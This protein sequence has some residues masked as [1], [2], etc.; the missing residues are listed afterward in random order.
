MDARA[1]IEVLE[2]REEVIG[3]RFLQATARAEVAERNVAAF[4]EEVQ[5]LRRREEALAE[6]L[7]QQTARA[8]AA[9]R[10]VAALEKKLT[11]Q[12]AA[13]EASAARARER[14]RSFTDRIRRMEAARRV[15]DPGTTPAEEALRLEVK[16]LED[17]L[18]RALSQLAEAL[19]LVEVLESEA[20]ERDAL[21]RR[22]PNPSCWYRLVDDGASRRERPEY[23]VD[24]KVLEGGVVLSPR[25]APPGGAQDGGSYA[26]ERSLLGV[27][28]WPYGR[29]VSPT[30]L[31]RLLAP[32]LAAGREARV[33][34]YP[35]VFYARIWDATPSAAKLA[36]KTG[37]RRLERWLHTFEVRDAPWPGAG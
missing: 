7:G 9:E 4:E 13:A 33:R 27:A 22:G 6:S 8:E 37:K 5:D 21:H 14:E 16:E 35:C 36:W 25:A 30:E 19:Q 20:A 1:S 10:N 28:G 24:V 11:A 34:P 32:V 26:E 31:D 17:G 2:A 23:L 29:L 12:M 15:P 18:G 3:E